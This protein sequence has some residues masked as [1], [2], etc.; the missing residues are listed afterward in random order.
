M[1][2]TAEQPVGVVTHWFGKLKVA[3]VRLDA[4][5]RV[6]DRLHIR[7]LHDDFKARVRSMHLNHQPIEAAKPGMEVGIQMPAR[8]H[9][10]AKVSRM[11]GEAGGLWGWLGRL[12]GS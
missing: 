2:A 12:L 9:V 11:E 4:P 6:G 5:V 3:T 10:G 1:T 8:A 7:G